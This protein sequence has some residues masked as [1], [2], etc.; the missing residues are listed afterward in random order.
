LGIPLLAGRAITGDD[1]AGA[2]PVV[3]L[4]QTAA[5]ALFGAENPIG[6]SVSQRDQYDAKSALQVIGVA[7]DV[8]FS[9]AREPFGF[10]LYV[11]LA[12]DPAPVTGIVVR[13]QAAATDLRAAVK[14]VDP[15]LKI[16][17]IHTFAD[18]FDASLGDDKLLAIIA[19]AFA[20]LALA[21]SYVGVYGLLSYAVE[22]RTREIGIRIALGAARADVYRMVLREAAALSAVSVLLGGVAAIATTRSLRSTLFGFAPAD[23]TLPL[24]AAALLC[25]AALSA[26]FLPARRATTVDPISALR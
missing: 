3:V 10:V 23:Y 18:A 13:S 26:A 15:N 25:L 6:R 19:A 16:G 1:R 17:P 9:N 20:L 8:R 5:R 7:R 11:P 12:Q 24:L 14:S 21:I 2:P 4:N 22:R